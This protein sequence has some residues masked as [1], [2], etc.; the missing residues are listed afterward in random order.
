MI[1]DNIQPAALRRANGKAVVLFDGVCNLCNGA[2][3]FIVRRDTRHKFMFASLQ[4]E[5]G[6]ELLNHYG[7]PLDAYESMVLLKG[8]KLYQKS[9]AALEIA[10][11]LPGG[12]SLMR[13]FKGVPAPLRN[14]IYSFI[15]T[16]RYRFFG[17]KETCRLPTPDERSRFLG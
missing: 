5:A 2:V 9:T 1:K 11:E 12:W 10:S 3:D 14:A 4:S 8:G 6:Q 17:K 13:I 15:A 7:L 16:N